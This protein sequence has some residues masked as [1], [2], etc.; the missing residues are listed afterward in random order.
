MRPKI[1]GFVAIAIGIAIAFGVFA[2]Q[3]N[4]ENEILENR[5]F[6]VTLASPDVYHNGIFIDSFQI[7]EGQYEFSFVP[8]GDSPKVM[9]I[10]LDGEFFYFEERFELEGTPHE[11]GVSTYYTWDYSG[12]KQIQIDRAQEIE[13]TIDPNGDLLGPVSVD[14]IEK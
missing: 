1:G 13:I 6:H 11:T 3:E 4:G 8:N 7:E 9:T 12:D 5:V 2:S 14:I 10:I